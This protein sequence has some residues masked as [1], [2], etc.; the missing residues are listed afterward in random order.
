MRGRDGVGKYDCKGMAALTFATLCHLL[1]SPTPAC[2]SPDARHT[3]IAIE[4]MPITMAME[5]HASIRIPSLTTLTSPSNSKPKANRP[6]PPRAQSLCH[7]LPRTPLQSHHTT[8]V[9]HPALI[10]PIGAD[11]AASSGQGTLQSRNTRI[12]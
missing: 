7:P 2:R 12:S 10:A 9:G 6:L 11:Q 1:P 5:A 4:C 3:P 8:P